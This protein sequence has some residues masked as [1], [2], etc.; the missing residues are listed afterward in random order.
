MDILYWRDISDLSDDV[1]IIKKTFNLEKVNLNFQN[2]SL[3]HY[4]ASN[5]EVIQLFFDR[6]MLEKAN[7]QISQT[8]KFLP[9]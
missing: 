9:L 4:F 7:N 3:F 8:T 1:E 2:K 5:P 6:F